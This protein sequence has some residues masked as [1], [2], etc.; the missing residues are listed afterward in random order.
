MLVGGKV[1]GVTLENARLEILGRVLGGRNMEV[2]LRELGIAVRRHGAFEL[3]SS[4][5]GRKIVGGSGGI[6]LRA[7]QECVGRRALIKASVSTWSV[8]LH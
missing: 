6:V 8:E 1:L 5:R 2:V 3:E 4:R 7:T